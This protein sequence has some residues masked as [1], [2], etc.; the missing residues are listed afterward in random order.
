MGCNARKTIKQSWK[1][2]QFQSQTVYIN[3]NSLS[4]FSILLQIREK[5][6]TVGPAHAMMAYSECR[7]TAPVIRNI[8][9]LGGQLYGRDKAPVPAAHDA[10]WAPRT[11]LEDLGEQKNLLPVTRI[12]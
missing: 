3:G 10:K 6:S 2:A 12:E 9:K 8:C 7:G 5:K 11:G 1:R 4:L